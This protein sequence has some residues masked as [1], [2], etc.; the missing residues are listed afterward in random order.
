[1][2]EIAVNL[3]FM[4]LDDISTKYL[5]WLN[6]KSYLRYS[7]QRF[8]THNLDSAK[9]YVSSFDQR[10]SILFKIEYGSDFAGT[11]TLI[12]DVQNQ[13]GVMGILVGKDFSNKGVAKY[14]WKQALDFGFSQLNL[15]K[16]KA[17]T[18]RSNLAMQR[19]FAHTG[20]Q[21]E[22]IL[23]DDLLID[24]N[25]EDLLLFCIYRNS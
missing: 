7:N 1:M 15:R 5:S 4:T 18:A 16:I 21:Q 14:A 20:M 23:S 19:I 6:D 12:C 17:G 2:A 24:G 8:F 9:K 10:D 3:N 22:A 25:Y 13:V 11:L